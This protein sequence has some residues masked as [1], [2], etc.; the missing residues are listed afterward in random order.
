MSKK[1]TVAPTR[2]YIT[3]DGRYVTEGDP[4]A[5][6]LYVSEGKEIDPKILESLDVTEDTVCD[7][8]GGEFKSAAGLASHQRAK[9]DD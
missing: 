9:H 8:C 7:E 5:A 6:F 2:I 4:A 3:E 1:K